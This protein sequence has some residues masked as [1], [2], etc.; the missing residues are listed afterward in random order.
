MPPI[1]SYTIMN[2]SFKTLRNRSSSF[3]EPAAAHRHYLHA[4]QD[5]GRLASAAKKRQVSKLRKRR[6]PKGI[7]FITGDD[8]CTDM[9]SWAHSMPARSQI[10][11]SD[12]RWPTWEDSVFNNRPR[13]E[14]PR[15]QAQAI[16]ELGDELFSI[17]VLKM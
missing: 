9:P 14:I 1:H 16:E 13:S 11:D 10:I 17:V 7:Q 4:N 8:N 15:N 6:I 2:T 5:D 3:V 12:T